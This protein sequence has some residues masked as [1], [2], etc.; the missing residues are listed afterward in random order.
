MFDRPPALSVER[1]LGLC[2]QHLSARD[3]TAMRALLT[4][5]N[6]AGHG[7]SERW[8]RR[9]T[10]LRN[11]AARERAARLGRKA[12]PYIR[13]PD[14]ADVFVAK[15][16]SDAMAKK[17]PMEVERALDRLRWETI[18]ELQ[19]SGI[20]SSNAILGY[21]LKLAIAERWAGMETTRGRERVD[22]LA[23]QPAV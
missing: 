21:G 22:S 16:V 7:F 12:D 18:E 20:F 23:G 19:G 17:N 5:G 10:A 8:T 3:M 9:E 13:Q 11:A 14:T 15:A 4:Q 1:F 6:A 2:E